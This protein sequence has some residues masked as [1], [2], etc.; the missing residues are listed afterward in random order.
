MVKPLQTSSQKLC[1]GHSLK[2]DTQLPE[3]SLAASRGAH[4]KE[5]GIGD[6]VRTE[7]QVQGVGVLRGII[8]Y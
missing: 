7:T 6:E 8:T 2:S 5:A 4:Q 3:P 1:L